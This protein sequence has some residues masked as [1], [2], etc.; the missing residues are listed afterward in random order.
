MTLGVQFSFI[1]STVMK[2]SIKMHYRKE[3]QLLLLCFLYHKG[4]CN[5]P[6]KPILASPVFATSKPTKPDILFVLLGYCK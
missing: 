1:N 2:I 6:T 5:L 4:T 3:H